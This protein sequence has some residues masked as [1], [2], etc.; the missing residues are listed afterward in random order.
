MLAV[1]TTVSPRVAGIGNEVFPWAKAYLLAREL[2]GVVVDPPWQLSPHRYGKSLR[3]SPAMLARYLRGQLGPHVEITREVLEATGETDYRAALRVL[4]RER[5]FEARDAR[6]AVVDNTGMYGGYPA[7][8][9][10]RAWLRAKLLSAEPQVRAIQRVFDMHDQV[11]VG[12]HIR[13]G[14]FASTSSQSLVGQF[15][16]RLPFSWYASVISALDDALDGRGVF[17]VVSTDDL[18]ELSSFF[19]SLEGRV[20]FMGGTAVEDLATLQASDLLVCSISSFSLLGAFLSSAPYVW[21]NEQITVEQGWASIWGAEAGG[22]GASATSQNRARVQDL[23][24]PVVP[25]GFVIGE[26]GSIPRALTQ[27]VLQSAEARRRSTD[28][29]YYGTYQSGR[30]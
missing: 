10:A 29:I 14:D 19:A 25:R 27:L 4:R 16:V 6:F 8:V 13:A 17:C 7:I 21:P 12:V 9:G 11:V 3:A 5:F 28:L 2:G 24:S 15:N 18:G 1:G 23:M 26:G 22:A 20:R 30:A